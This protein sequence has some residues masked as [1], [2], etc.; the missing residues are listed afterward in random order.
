MTIFETLKTRILMKSII[1]WSAMGQQT[2]PSKRVYYQAG[3]GK[4][5]LT[6]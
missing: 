4:I 2:A 3:E 5:V 6:L 1:T